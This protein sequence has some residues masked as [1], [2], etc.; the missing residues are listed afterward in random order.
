MKY[1]KKYPNIGFLFGNGWCKVE[2]LTNYKT[3]L[4]AYV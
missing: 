2:N 4:L 3:T 1:P